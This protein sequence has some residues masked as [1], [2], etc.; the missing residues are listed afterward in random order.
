MN[1]SS[2]V[3]YHECFTMNVSTNNKLEGLQ[4][5][6]Y[7]NWYIDAACSFLC[8]SVSV[9][10]PSDI[11][12]P[13]AFGTDTVDSVMDEYS[14]SLLYVSSHDRMYQYLSYASIFSVRNVKWLEMVRK[15]SHFH[16]YITCCA[17]HSNVTFL[18]CGRLG[19]SSCD[20]II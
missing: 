18:A 15:L 5:V 13:N 8:H 11:I 16:C 9:F 10:F 2:W 3:F 4:Y 17:S 14:N 20:V 6:L 7:Y 12:I 19:N 1:V